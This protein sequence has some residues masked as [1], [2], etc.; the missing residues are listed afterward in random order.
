MKK[1]IIVESNLYSN[2]EERE[3]IYRIW[4]LNVYAPK[5]EDKFPFCK[6][7]IVSRIYG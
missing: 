7:I 1:W 3:Q 4:N 5:V 6:S 2:T